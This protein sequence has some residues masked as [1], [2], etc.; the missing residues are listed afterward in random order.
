MENNELQLVVRLSSMSA[1][2]LCRVSCIVQYTSLLNNG[3]TSAGVL[4]SM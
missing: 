2:I 1:D 4:Q 3:L